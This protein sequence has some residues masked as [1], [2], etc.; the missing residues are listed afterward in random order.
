MAEESMSGG[1]DAQEFGDE[2]PV[3]PV[4][5]TEPLPER[6]RLRL[7]NRVLL[8]TAILFALSAGLYVRWPVEGE[9]I[10]EASR[11]IL[12]AIAT[13]VLGYYFGRHSQ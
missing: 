9:P 6:E 8:G 11:T 12:P 2:T 4:A 10:F 1:V 13:L 7:A 3:P 5:R